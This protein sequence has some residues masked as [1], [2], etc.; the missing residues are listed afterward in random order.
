M[1]AA[2]AARVTINSEGEAAVATTGSGP[3]RPCGGVGDAGCSD[4]YAFTWLG[5]R[6]VVS[7]QD[8]TVGRERRERAVGAGSVVR[9]ARAGPE[10][11][12]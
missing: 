11:G 12:E 7:V 5:S 10:S 9:S 2:Q 4:A 8:S 1:G 3:G 6:C